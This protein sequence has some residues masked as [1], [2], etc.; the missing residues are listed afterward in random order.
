MVRKLVKTRLPTK[1]II[2]R[3]LL[4]GGIMS[5]ALVAP[6][7]LTLVKHLNRGG[8]HRKD[9]Y[10]RITQAITKLERSG[11]VRT[12]GTFGNR[13]VSLTKK[14]NSEIERMFANEYHIPEPLFWDGKWR[15]VMFDIREERKQVRE[16]LRVLLTG[17]GFLRIQDSVWVY[18]YPCDD[19]IALVRAH[20]RSGTGE[21]LSFVAEALEADRKLREHFKLP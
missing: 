9:L 10:R 8:V 17:A 16:Q 7:A 14:G 1:Q 15:M 11:F 13:K 21:M 6:N 5:V 2:L 3:A 4:A 19:F 12:S 18:P 20:L